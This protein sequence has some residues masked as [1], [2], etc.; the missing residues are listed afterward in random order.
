MSS[1][2]E[3]TVKPKVTQQQE[4]VH[5][6]KAD[7]FQMVMQAGFAYAATSCFSAVV[8][9]RIA[10]ALM[11]GP[12]NVSELAAQTSANEDILYRVLRALATMGIFT[13]TT[14][15]TF[16][17]TPASEILAEDHPR[18]MRD[19]ALWMSDAFHFDIFRDM[20]PTLRDGK[21]AIEHVFGK[22]AFDV[23]FSNAEELSVFNNAMTSISAVSIP[24]VLEHYDFSG[25]G[26]TIA[27]IAGGHGYVLT[28]ILEKH[29]Q[30]RGILFD[31]DHVLE[32]ARKRVTQLGLT[33]RL[34]FVPG[35]FFESV[36]PADG[37]LMKHIIHDWDNERALT[38]LRNCSKHLKKGG[39]LV[40][41][42]AVVPPGNEPG[43]SKWL[44]IEM[45]MLPGGKERSEAEY[46][47]LLSWAGLRLNRIVPTDCPLSVLESEK[48]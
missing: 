33:D 43:Y 8:R 4:P 34:Q 30:M 3:S 25:M 13:E 35:N 11:E 44:D 6:G 47:E 9:L 10:D 18:S 41:I 27:D 36:P 45:L 20:L 5:A 19:M 16:A 24:T 40:L 2:F 21:P 1:T 28:A 15:R 39:K 7:P 14:P 12:K 42:E 48:D 46:R 29:P 32:G 17:N 38:I 26:A 22:P 37:Y 23:L 31:V